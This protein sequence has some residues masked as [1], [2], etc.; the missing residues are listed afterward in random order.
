[1]KKRVILLACVLVC[2]ISLSS[3]FSLGSTE[4]VSTR[5]QEYNTDIN[6]ELVPSFSDVAASTLDPR[7]YFPDENG[8]MHYG[9]DTVRTYTG[10]DVSVF[11]GE[12]DWN[13][14]KN[15][16]IDFVMLRA[17]YRGYGQKGILGEDE[18]FRKNAAAARAAGLEVGAYF[19][20]QA[21]DAAEAREEAAFVLD[22][23]KDSD[24]TY[25]VAFDW[26][27]IDYDTARTDGMTSE[28]ITECASAFCDTISAAGYE[29]LIYFN[30]EVGYFNYDLSVLNNYH[31]WLAEYSDIPAFYYDYKIWQYSMHGSVAGINGDVDMNI[32]LRDFSGN[33]TV[34]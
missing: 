23:I 13:A 6:G 33:S 30:C 16:G 17:G 34:G 21:T 19:F 2:C 31:F 32:C 14:V 12:I 15:D 27:I 29:P 4:E 24:I 1:M 11:Q 28:K 20:S 9:D 10:I 18:S 25:P 7:A 8:R 5:A 3:C 26:E 22:I